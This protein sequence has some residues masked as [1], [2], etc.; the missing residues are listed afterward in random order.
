MLMK[1]DSANDSL[2]SPH[3]DSSMMLEMKSNRTTTVQPLSVEFRNVTFSYPARPDSQ[4][5]GP[6]FS[7]SIRAGEAVALVGAS[8]GGKSTIASLLTRLY[9][10]T[11]GTIYIDGVDICNMTPQQVRE[12]VGIVAQEPLLFPT[13]IA[14]NIRYGRLSATNEEIIEAARLANVLDFCARF[15]NGLD[16]LVG[17]RGTQLSGGQRQRVAVARAILKN[18]RIVIFDEATSAL[19][20]ESENQVQKAIDTAMKGRTVIS[21]AHRL[22]SIKNADRIAVLEDG[23]V[24]E[25]GTFDQLSTKTTGAFRELMKRQLIENGASSKMA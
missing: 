8:G 7:L 22:S 20:S 3:Y 23:R 14:E 10:V 11:S 2:S 9:N 25:I 15:P 18:P 16:T 24:R 13:T 5:I 21:I 4:V 12:N 1:N 6:G 17:S 19:D